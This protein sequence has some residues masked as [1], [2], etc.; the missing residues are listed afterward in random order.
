MKKENIIFYYHEFYLYHCINTLKKT[1]NIEYYC[2]PE[3][4]DVI[5]YDKENNTNLAE[6]VYVY[7][8]F[9]NMVKTA[10]HLNIHRNTLIYRL[11]RFK[12][13]TNIDLSSGND[14]YKLWLSYLILELSPNLIGD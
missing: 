11:E 3:L 10:K 13:L 1:G 9:R 5:Q 14:I 4:I 2:L 12:E 6:T 8:H 7:L